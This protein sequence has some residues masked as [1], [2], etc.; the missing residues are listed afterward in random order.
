MKRRVLIGRSGLAALAARTGSSVLLGGCHT[1][2]DMIGEPT[3]SWK[4]PLIRAAQE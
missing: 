4:N 3:G 2:E 1:E